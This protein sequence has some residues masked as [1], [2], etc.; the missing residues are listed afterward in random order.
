MTLIFSEITELKMT[1]PKIIQGG[2]GAAV[3]DWRLAKAV[4]VEGQLGVVSGTALDVIMIRRLQSGDEGGHVRRALASFPV[5]KIAERI[6][7]EYFVE[8]GQKA[9]LPLSKYKMLTEAP[10]LKQNEDLVAANFVEVFLAKE[11]HDGIVG[12]NLLEKIQIANPASLFGTMLAGVDYVIMGA[13]IPREIPGILDKFAKCEPIEMRLAVEGE[14]KDE[15]HFVTFDPACILGDEKMELKR[16]KFL[17]IIASN[18]LATTMVKKATGKVDGL[19]IENPTAGGHNAPPRGGMTL[20]DTGQPAYSERDEVDLDKIRKLDVPFWLA[21]SY[22]SAEMLKK[23]LDEG[24]AGI[25]AGTVFAFCEESGLADDLKKAGLQDPE[26][27][28]VFTDPKASPTGFPFKVLSIEGTLSEPEVYK[29]RTRVCNLGFLRHI[30]SVDGK[31]GYRCPAEPIQAYV[32]KGGLEEECEGR[33]CLCNG[34]LADIDL[35]VSYPDGRYERALVTVGDDFVSLAKYIE[36]YGR[37]YTAKD[38][39]DSLKAYL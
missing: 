10:T 36:K 35:A 1:L 32:K 27:A 3:S 22:G 39:I 33:K 25:Q 28:V 18:I 21:G 20:D 13:G 4:S 14:G 12:L 30:F 29:E 5:K 16:P 38:V 31:L 11:G 37:N 26:N 9:P 7:E 6:I 17:A 15:K 34:L 8:N 23:A 24:A 2:M 19:V